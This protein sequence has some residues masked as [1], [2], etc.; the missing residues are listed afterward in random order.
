[1]PP[2][3]ISDRGAWILVSV[4]IL[5]QV[6]SKVSLGHLTYREDDGYWVKQK[7]GEMGDCL[8]GENINVTPLDIFH[9]LYVN[10]T[11]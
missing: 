5:I 6:K 1:M 4:L 2:K 8:Q 11:H 7:V 3:H 10:K 9:Q